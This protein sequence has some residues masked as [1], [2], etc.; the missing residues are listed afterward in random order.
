MYYSTAIIQLSG[1]WAWLAGL[2]VDLV[3]SRYISMVACNEEASFRVLDLLRAFL[4]LQNVCSG[5]VSV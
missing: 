1:F 5:G 2:G 3:I 4:V